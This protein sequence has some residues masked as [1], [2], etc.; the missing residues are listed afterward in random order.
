VVITG[1]SA[2]TATLTITTTAATSAPLSPHPGVRSGR[3]CTTGSTTLAFLL[4]FGIRGP[5]RRWRNLLRLVGLLVVLAGGVLPCGGGGG[6]GG[7]GTPGTTPGAYS[8]TVTGTS[9][10][11]SASGTV[12][13]TVQ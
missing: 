4:F 12:S 6:G 8:I 2:G 5:R 13:L 9:G 11:L 10:T 1:T 3:W 7:T